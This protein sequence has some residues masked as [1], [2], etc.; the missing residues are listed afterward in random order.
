MNGSLLYTNLATDLLAATLKPGFMRAWKK[1]DILLVK[2]R[3]KNS[4]MNG[5]N[6][7][8]GSFSFSVAARKMKG[9]ITMKKQD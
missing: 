2:C 8:F 1:S 4:Q 5:N 3:I 9:T 7:L 6:V